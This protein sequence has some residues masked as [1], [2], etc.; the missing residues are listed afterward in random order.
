MT[1]AKD[2]NILNTDNRTIIYSEE[3]R[4]RDEIWARED[5][6]RCQNDRKNYYESEI[7]ARDAALAEK[8]VV[9]ADKEATIA[10]I[11]ATIAVKDATIADKDAT[12]EHLKAMLIANGINPDDNQ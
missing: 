2:T 12:I 3:Q 7:A 9:I 6:I 5:F 10:D 1:E 8:D 11:D 4:I